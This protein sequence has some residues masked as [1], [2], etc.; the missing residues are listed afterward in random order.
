MGVKRCFFCGHENS[1]NAKFCEECNAPLDPQT[2]KQTDEKIRKQE[3]HIEELLKFV[4]EN[5]PE[6]IIDFYEE[7]EKVREL[8]QLGESEVEA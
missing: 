7:R 5:H 1:P 3:G 4:K 2:A 6:A 8:E